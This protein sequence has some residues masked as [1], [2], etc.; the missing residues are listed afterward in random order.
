[1]GAA[2]HSPR[3]WGSGYLHFPS[4]WQTVEEFPTNFIP[5]WQRKIIDA[6]NPV[7]P[8]IFSNQPFHNLPGCPQF[9]STHAQKKST[10]KLASTL[11]KLTFTDW[12]GARPFS[13]RPTP[14]SFIPNQSVAIL[15]LVTNY[16]VVA[17]GCVDCFAVSGV[18]RGWTLY[19]CNHNTRKPPTKLSLYLQN[20]KS[21]MDK[22]VVGFDYAERSSKIPFSLCNLHTSE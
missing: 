11:L 22:V 10:V 14:S 8:S 12:L 18:F 9:I 5:S 4:I 13:V 20:V 19:G 7:P 6:P 2:K 16:G 15:A 3:H 1:M 21:L 17:A